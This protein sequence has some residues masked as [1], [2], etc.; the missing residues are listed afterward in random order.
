M[1]SLKPIAT[2]DG[3]AKKNPLVRIS[4]EWVGSD[5]SLSAADS[6]TQTSVQQFRENANIEGVVMF[7]N[8]AQQPEL[9]TRAKFRL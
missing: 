4:K 8:N 3:G 2:A 1:V 7:A 9:E 6:S 5:K